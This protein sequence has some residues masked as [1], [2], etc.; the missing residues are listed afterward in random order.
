VAGAVEVTFWVV[1]RVVGDVQVE[2]VPKMK[3]NRPVVPVLET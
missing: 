2:P 1:M 3:V